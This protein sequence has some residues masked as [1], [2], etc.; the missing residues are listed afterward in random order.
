MKVSGGLGNQLNFYFYKKFIE[1]NF[2]KDVYFDF[3]LVDKDWQCTNYFKYFG[4]KTEALPRNIDLS[5]FRKLEEFENKEE[6]LKENKTDLAVYSFYMH[7]YYYI[8][9]TYDYLKDI[10]LD[11]GC[12]DDKDKEILNKIGN[13]ESVC[14]HLRRGD[15]YKIKA[16]RNIFGVLD[17]AYYEKAIN[18]IKERTSNPFFFVFSDEPSES[19]K[20]I[21]V[22]ENICIVNHNISRHYSAL[23]N[24]SAF[25][26]MKY[27]LK[28]I[29]T[30]KLEKAYKDF[31]LMTKCKH[32]IISNSTFS[33]WSAF[34]AGNEQKIV[35]AP[36]KWST[37]RTSEETVPSDWIKL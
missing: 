20:I 27:L 16:T 6:I 12:I 32:H 14:I 9:R 29:N 11:F 30:G 19:S 13:T 28:R 31:F 18:Y 15:Y 35:I 37:K 23:D 7:P 8:H 24:Y 17:T 33:W 34:L 1:N 21:D 36:Y 10:K 25:R 4:L 3:E 22:K 26:K 5:K 2:C